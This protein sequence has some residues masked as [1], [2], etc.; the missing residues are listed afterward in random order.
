VCLSD[1]KRAREAAVSAGRGYLVSLVNL[2]HDTMPKS[3]DARV[4]PTPPIEL[5]EDDATL[6]YLIEAGYMLCGTPDEVCEQI[7][8][9]QNVGCDQLV[10]GLPG[11]GMEHEEILEMLELFGD[12]VI[13][14]YD[15]DPIH[16]T[17]RYRQS[18][19]PRFPQFSQ[20]VPDIDIDI[21][22]V[23]ALLPLHAS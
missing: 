1:R 15:L 4:W 14:E 3:P 22:P 17:T 2:Y 19:K 5:P 23:S 16:S 12:K 20:P 10:F 8:A 21:L 11:E 13:P 7:A 18:A 6:D 9:Y